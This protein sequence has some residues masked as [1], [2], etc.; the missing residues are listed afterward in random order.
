M[1]VRYLRYIYSFE[2]PIGCSNVRNSSIANRAYSN[3]VI[4]TNLV[5]L[6]SRTAVVCGFFICSCG[7]SAKRKPNGVAHT[8]YPN[9]ACSS[10]L[11][12]QYAVSV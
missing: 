9:V 1:C 7:F 10:G 2:I 12:E 3:Y 11:L 5:R 6:S 8:Y 4:L